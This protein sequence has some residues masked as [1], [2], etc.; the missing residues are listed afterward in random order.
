[1]LLLLIDGLLF[2]T[3]IMGSFLMVRS[4]FR[5]HQERQLE[6]AIFRQKVAEDLAKQVDILDNETMKLNEKKIQDKLNGLH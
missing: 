4:I 1:M 2:A 5:K 6:Q 3:V